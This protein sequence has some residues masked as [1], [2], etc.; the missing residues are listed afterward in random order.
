MEY[1]KIL[2]QTLHN[3]SLY[4]K[5]SRII[6]EQSSYR[7]QFYNFW[8]QPNEQMYWY[9]FLLSRRLLPEGKTAA[10]FSVFGDRSIIERVHADMKV[11]FTGENLKRDSF[12]QYTDHC[13]D[14]QTIDLAMGFEVFEH[15]RY[16]RFPLWMMDCMFPA[17][18]SEDAIRAKCQQVRFPNINEKN[19]FCSMIASNSADGMRQEMYEQ[20]S[21]IAHVDSAGRFMHNDDALQNKF[22]DNKSAYLQSYIFNICP[23]NSSAYGYTTEKIFEAITAGCIPIYWGAEFADKQ[24]I[25][26]DAVIRWNR[27]DNGHSAVRQVNDLYSN[28]KLLHEFLSQ[29]RLLP[30]AEEYIL[31]TF[32]TIEHKILSIFHNQ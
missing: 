23:E 8:E 27:E 24:V 2:R 20:I 9:Q 11:F 3:I 7:V 16:I 15:P 29:P 14:N 10:F 32:D 17:D 13:L 30:T 6:R 26:E 1:M 19:K 25:N 22:D 18:S 21:Q 4:Q 31:D 12:V 5:Q 28:P